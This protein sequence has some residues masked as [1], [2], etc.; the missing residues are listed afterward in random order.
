MVGQFNRG[1]TSLMNALLGSDR[2]P[3]GVLPLTCVV[4][5]LC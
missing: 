4:T 2:L 5:A 3:T 1:K